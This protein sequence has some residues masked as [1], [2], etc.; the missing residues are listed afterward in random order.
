MLIGVAMLNENFGSN[1]EFKNYINGEWVGGG[2]AFENINPSDLSDKI[3]LISAATSQQI[4]DA[5]VGAKN[6]QKEWAATGIEKRAGLLQKIG[7]TLIARS[8]TVGELLAREEGKTRAEGIGEV[9]RSGQFFQYYAAQSLRLMG[10]FCDSVRPGVEV[11]VLRDP[12]GT[13][14]IVAPWNFPVAVPAWKMAP[15]LAFGNSVVLKPAQLTSGSAC[16]LFEIIEEVGMPP[17]L[18]QLL[19]GK[20]SV[21]GD[22]LIKHDGFDA[23]SFTGSLNTGRLIAQES[24]SRL[25]R[26]QLEMGSKNALVVVDDADLDVAVACAVNGAFFGTGQKCTASSRIIVTDKIHDAFLEKFVEATK[27]LKVGH[28]LHPDSQIGPCVNAEELASN[29]HYVAVAK[30][31]G[32]GVAWEGTVGQQETEGHYFAPVIFYNTKNDMTINREEVFGPVTCLIKANDYEEALHMSNDTDYGLTSGIITTS[33]KTANHFKRHAQ[34][35]C[36][37]VN[38]PTAGTD[39]HV[40]FGGN[41]LSSFGPREQG[42]YAAEFYTR[43]K[44]AYIKP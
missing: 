21:V 22:Q 28:A 42:S 24:A 41:K 31:E 1:H 44:T 30:K 2:S 38:L 15:A 12:V 11:E 35:G 33:L 14:L 7:D 6:A 39:Y 16:A 26:F 37:M 27:V 29:Q 5:L 13:V 19:L 34:S 18:C 32:A 4:N 9:Y 23:V 25:R 3:G 40:P 20:G 43:V 36:V 8:A 10:D 17:G